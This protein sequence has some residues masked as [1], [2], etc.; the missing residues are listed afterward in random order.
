MNATAMSLRLV[1]LPLFVMPKSGMNSVPARHHAHVVADEQSVRERRDRQVERSRHAA[2]APGD[3]VG[4]LREPVVG[5][6]LGRARGVAAEVVVGDADR[7]VVAVRHRRN[8]RLHQRVAVHA[9]R[10]RPGETAIERARERD[11]VAHAAAEPRVL[12]DQRKLRRIR[13]AAIEA[14]S[15]PSRTG[16]PFSGS[17]APIDC[18]ALI[19]IGS[20]PGHALVRR[21]HDLQRRDVLVVDDVDAA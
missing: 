4:G 12:P 9:H 13:L 6:K 10:R 1:R 5:R 15:A 8:E 19:V 14:I 21:A 18:C 7:A 3:A 20:A 2:L 17:V 11:G 16:V